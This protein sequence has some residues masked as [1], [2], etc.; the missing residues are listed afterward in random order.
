MSK[1]KPKSKRANCHY[2]DL[3]DAHKNLLFK[4]KMSKSETQ[5]QSLEKRIKEKAMEIAKYIQDNPSEFNGLI[6][7]GSENSATASRLEDLE[8]QTAGL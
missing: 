5:K 7:K 4:F 2:N 8:R 1:R 3:V 6:P